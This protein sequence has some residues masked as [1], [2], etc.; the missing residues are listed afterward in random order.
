[1]CKVL[2]VY[3]GAGICCSYGPKNN[4]INCNNCN[5]Q[6][7]DLGMDIGGLSVF[8]EKGVRDNNCPCAIVSI[9]KIDEEM[10][11]RLFAVLVG[12]LVCCCNT[13]AQR[14]PGTLTLYP[15]VG[16][17]LSKFSGDKIYRETDD[18]VK[19]KFKTGWVFGAEMQYQMSCPLAISGGVMFSQQGTSFGKIEGVDNV[20]IGANNINVPLM[21][22][23][24]TKYGISAKIGVQP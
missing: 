1:M 8:R 14:E 7:Q 23:A 9:E 22:V 12:T 15:R 17:N 4:C 3:W 24:T 2:A 18:Y 16:L 11:K 5:R 10:K 20:E 21:L 19:S 13:F 6:T